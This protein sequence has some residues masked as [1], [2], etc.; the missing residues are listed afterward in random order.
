MSYRV[1][2]KH[3]GVRELGTKSE[4]GVSMRPAAER[5]LRAAR[6]KAPSWFMENQPTWYVKGGK[7]PQGAFAQAVARGDGAVLAEFGGRYTAPSFMFR[8]SI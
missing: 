3:S 8:S 6:S 4:V 7:G 5:I 1:I 2:V